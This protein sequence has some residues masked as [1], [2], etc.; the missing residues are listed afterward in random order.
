MV[1]QDTIFS[2]D[3]GKFCGA[4]QK[5]S[6]LFCHV[7]HRHVDFPRMNTML[8]LVRAIVSSQFL[9]PK[10][11]TLLDGSNAHQDWSVLVQVS[12]LV[13]KPLC[14]CAEGG[15]RDELLTHG[16]TAL[17]QGSLRPSPVYGR[18]QFIM[19]RRR[20]T[21]AEYPHLLESEEAFHVALRYARAAICQPM[22]GPT[23]LLVGS[24]LPQKACT[25]CRS[26]IHRTSIRCSLPIRCRLILTPSV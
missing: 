2:I 19:N 25:S 5:P 12:A 22:N 18:R 6:G 11:S 8:W 24:I 26:R 1:C 16:S 10:T 7:G 3:I 20:S 14:K 9:G 13:G 23:V 17:I 4:S 15:E 21:A